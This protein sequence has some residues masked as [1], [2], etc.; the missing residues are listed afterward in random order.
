M[1][2]PKPRKN[3][4]KD[5]YH[6]R[7]MGDA[8]MAKDY[9]N[10]AQRNAV[11]YRAWDAEHPE[12]PSAPTSQGQLRPEALDT[13]ACFRAHLGLWAIEPH[14]I[15]EAVLAIQRGL[16]PMQPVAAMGDGPGGTGALYATTEDGVAIIRIVGGLTKGVSKFGGTSAILTRRAIRQAVASEQVKSLL[17]A[18]DSPGGQVDGIQDVA[19]EVVRARLSKPVVAHIEDLGASAAYW[20]GSQ[21]QRITSN[22]SAQIG[23]IGVLAALEDTSGKAARDGVTVH[24]VT[25]SPYKAVGIPGAPVLPEH[26]AY[27]GDMVQ[28]MG[29]FFFE[30]VQRGR[31]MSNAQLK[32][33]TDGR[34]FLAQRAK[35]LGLIDGIM[36][37]DQ[38]VNDAARMRQPRRMAAAGRLSVAQVRA[39]WED[40]TYGGTG[41]NQDDC[42]P[43]GYAGSGCAKADGSRGTASGH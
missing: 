39:A 18:I 41:Q 37:F 4:H 11:C 42:N 20:I 25:T 17:L 12:N 9:P 28:S 24:V 7:C 30:A 27:L 16:W 6:S 33:V 14:W 5:V 8:T 31:K 2:N 22:R 32:A 26:L 21:A 19:D 23:S 1:S 3:E 34:V 29:T 35:E 10:I 13:V 36:S 40:V 43:A 15:R 38:A